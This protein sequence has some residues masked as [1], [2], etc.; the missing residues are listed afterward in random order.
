LISLLLSTLVGIA[1]ASAISLIDAWLSA[2][3]GYELPGGFSYGVPGG[4]SDRSEMGRHDLP[5]WLCG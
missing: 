2:V 5:P 4:A 1:L 3:E